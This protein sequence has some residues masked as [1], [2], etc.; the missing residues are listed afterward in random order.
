M[1]GGLELRGSTPRGVLTNSEAW[2]DLKWGLEVRYLF[3]SIFVTAQGLGGAHRP[4]GSK[5]VA[6]GRKQFL[7][8]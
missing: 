5:F 7:I 6:V 1:G 3:I 4:L 2:S 8:F